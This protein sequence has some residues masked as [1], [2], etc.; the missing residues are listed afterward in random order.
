MTKNFV[1]AAI[2][3][4]MLGGLAGYQINAF[5]T[6]MVQSKS[7]TISVDE[8]MQNFRVLPEMRVENVV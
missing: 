8:L 5:A 1:A 7:A 3:L 2:A 6:P 4:F